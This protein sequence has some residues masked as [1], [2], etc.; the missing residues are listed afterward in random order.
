MDAE[1]KQA[2]ADLKTS[3]A[4]A[5][6]SARAEELKKRQRRAKT[7][8]TTPQSALEEAQTSKKTLLGG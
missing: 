8:L 7:L 1:S 4:Q 5:E 2:A 6:E 3:A